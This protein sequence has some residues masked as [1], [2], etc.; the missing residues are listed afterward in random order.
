MDKQFIINAISN[1]IEAKREWNRLCTIVF[2][3]G[4]ELTET[5]FEKVISTHE[6]LVYKLLMEQSE[7]GEVNE[8]EFDLFIDSIQELA[9]NNYVIVQLSKNPNDPPYII[10]TPSE[11][12]ELYVPGPA[13]QPILDYIED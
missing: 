7:F 3:L 10:S 2:Q 9:H 6:E 13:I 12:Y 4:G 5:R 1:L 8:A 11:L